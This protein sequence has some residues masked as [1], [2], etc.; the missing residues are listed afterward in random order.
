MALEINPDN[1]AAYLSLAYLYQLGGDYRKAIDTYEKALAVN[2]NMW[3][4]ANNVA[5]L[6]SEHDGSQAALLRALNYIQVAQSAAPD[7]PAV[8]DT[9]GWIYHKLGYSMRAL[10]LI[11]KALLKDPENPIFNAHAGMIY[12]RTGYRMEAKEKLQKALESDDPFPGREK[13]EKLVLEFG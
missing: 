7:D 4:A 6:L 13:V 10:G 9:Q 1:P 5:Y 12:Y 8:L 3:L 11:E 2:P